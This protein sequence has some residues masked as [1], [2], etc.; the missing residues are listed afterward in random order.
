M[1]LGT[2]TTAPSFSLSDEATTQLSELGCA[3]GDKVNLTATH[4]E[5]GSYEIT[6]VDGKVAPESPAVEAA[7]DE[8]KGDV[9]D[10]EEKILG[11]K[12]PLGNKETP[13]LTSLL[14]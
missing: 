12:R 10:P 13:P 2:D 7:A 6:S 3:P 8:D 4:N 14:D 11:Y 1:D 5:D 9:V